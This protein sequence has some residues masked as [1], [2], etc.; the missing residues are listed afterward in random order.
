MDKVETVK[1]QI[2]PRAYL[3]AG[4]DLEPSSL[5]KMT[6]RELMEMALYLRT[7]K[8]LKTNQQKGGHYTI[9]G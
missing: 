9:G 1:N 3:A 2:S 8:I 5:K 4:G 7:M 6:K